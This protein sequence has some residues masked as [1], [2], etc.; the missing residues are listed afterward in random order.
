MIEI[1]RK[2]TNARMSKV[3]QHANLVYLCGQTASGG[4]SAGADITVQTHETL[5]RVDSLLN[6]AGTDRSR[7]LSATVYLRDISDF[8]A[9]NAVWESWVIPGTAPARTTVE[10]RLAGETLLVEVTVVA[11]L[12]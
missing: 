8:A 11:A 9:M 4:A 10:V 12:E 3:V 1:Q 5:S 2:H 6:E 7:I